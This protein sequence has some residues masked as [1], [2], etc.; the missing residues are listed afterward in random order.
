MTAAFTRNKPALKIS[1]FRG[2][3]DSR[4]NRKK[5]KVPAVNINESDEEYIVMM[6]APGF[7][8][9]A[10]HVRIE[11]N[12]LSVEAAKQDKNLNYIHGLCEYDLN[13]WKREF[14]LPDDAD[15]LMTRATYLN[16]E[17]IIRI[18]KGKTGSSP[19]IIP[20]YVY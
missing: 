10:L 4:P 1:T 17:L 9:E 13:S 20:I 12:I 14:V 8:K 19:Y 3:E 11:S 7:C 16:G 6:A 18:P 5:V 15:G 2:G